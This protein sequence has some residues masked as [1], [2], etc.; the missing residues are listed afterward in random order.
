MAI[1]KLVRTVGIKGAIFIGLGSIMGTGVFVSTGLAAGIAGPAALL[2]VF[3]AGMLALVNGLNS[4]Q[5]AAAHPVSGGTYEYGYRFVAPPIGFTAGWMFLIAKSMSAATAALGFGGYLLIMLPFTNSTYIIPLALAAVVVITVVVYLGL[6]R[7]NVV[8]FVIVSVTLASLAF[9]ILGSL[10]LYAEFGWGLFTPFFL[11]EKIEI[12]EI[13]YS[14]F[15]AT[16]IVFV[17]F[18]GYGRIATLGEEVIAPEKTIP[19]TVWITLG[20]TMLLYLLVL[21]GGIAALGPEGLYQAARGNASPLSTA[22]VEFGIPGAITILSIGA[23]TAMLGVL[24]NLIL[25]L[26]RVV[27]AMSRRGDLPSYFEKTNANGDSPRR[28]V[29]ACGLFVGALALIGD[30]YVTWSFSAFTVLI[31]YAIT[32]LSAI[33]IPDHLRLYPKALGYC[34]LGACLFIAFWVEQDVWLWGLGLI[35]IGLM[36]HGLRKPRH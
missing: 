1:Q 17:A 24:L 13:V 7:S 21:S 35:A 4:A 28:A 9:F 18:T 30:V 3:M 15:H 32:N 16:A 19:K 23:I 29:V 11:H 34:G 20:I 10:P 8:N 31:Y 26:S 5:L 2:A 36:V 27:L 33:R 25:G 14:V 12:T 22:A 6:R